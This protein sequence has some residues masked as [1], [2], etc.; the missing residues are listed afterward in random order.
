MNLLRR[1]VLH[2]RI[3]WIDFDSPL[4]CLVGSISFLL[5]VPVFFF[6]GVVFCH[7]CDVFDP[8]AAQFVRC[9]SVVA[10]A[11][12]GGGGGVDCYWWVGCWF[13]A[14]C[15]DCVS[16]HQTVGGGGDGGGGG[17]GGG[18]WWWWWFDCG[19]AVRCGS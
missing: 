3:R 19:C 4:F 18:W 15:C 12:A 2:C 6:H 7:D 1:I 11:A 17:G 8:G 16:F 14:L 10:I 5:D 13:G 9:D